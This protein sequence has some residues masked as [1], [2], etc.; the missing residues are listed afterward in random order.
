MEYPSIAYE[1]TTTR[2]FYVAIGALIVVAA[3]LIVVAL[4]V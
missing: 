4:T 2:I 3:A 1:Q